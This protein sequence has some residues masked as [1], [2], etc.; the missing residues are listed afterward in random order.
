MKV[1]EHTVLQAL[2]QDPDTELTGLDLADKTGW[3]PGTTYPVLIRLQQAG[4]IT[5]RWADTD[6]PRHRYYRVTTAGVRQAQATTVALRQ[7][8]LRPHLAR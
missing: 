5:A 6:P 4:Y 7:G 2:A 3:L 8:N 1:R